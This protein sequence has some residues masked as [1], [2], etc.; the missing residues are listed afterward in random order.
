MH[1]LPAEVPAQDPVLRHGDDRLVAVGRRTGRLR[2]VDVV[3]A[4]DRLAAGVHGPDRRVG[5]VQGLEERC[6]T[7]LAVQQEQT[8]L[9]LGARLGARERSG[10]EA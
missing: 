5:D 8:G 2:Y 4:A 10:T 6:Q 7:L 1:D 3:P 9:T